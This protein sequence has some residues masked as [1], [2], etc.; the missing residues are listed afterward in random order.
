MEK[1]CNYAYFPTSGL[2]K[3]GISQENIQDI[4]GMRIMKL[5]AVFGFV[6]SINKKFDFYTTLSPF[7][8]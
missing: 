3:Y 7:L 8:L 4:L 5:Y 6:H 2:R 1:R